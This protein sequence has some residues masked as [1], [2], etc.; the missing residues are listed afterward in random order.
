MSASKRGCSPV[1]LYAACRLP[2][3]T[4]GLNSWGRMPGTK[5][6]E[7]TESFR[8]IQVPEHKKHCCTAQLLCVYTNNG[9]TYIYIYIYIYAYIYICIYIYIHTCS[10]A[11]VAFHHDLRVPGSC[12]LILRALPTRLN[13]V[14][15][16]PPGASGKAVGSFCIGFGV[17]F[18]FGLCSALLCRSCRFRSFKQAAGLATEINAQV[19]LE[20]YEQRIGEYGV[21]ILMLCTESSERAVRGFRGCFRH[22][23]GLSIQGIFQS[24][25]LWAPS[26][27]KRL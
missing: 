27:F 11:F 21:L 20:M 16:G 2:V 18:L 10:M 25:A 9:Y 7:S 13:P 22:L 15:W 5:V 26:F 8:R 12:W 3:G 6:L 1:T 24:A 23:L 19:V 14:P 4:A 17:S